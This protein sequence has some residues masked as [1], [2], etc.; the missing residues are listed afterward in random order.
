MTTLTREGGTPKTVREIGVELA[1]AFGECKPC[2]KGTC[3]HGEDCGFKEKQE[4][5]VR[6]A[7]C[8]LN[9]ETVKFTTTRS[10]SQDL[11]DPDEVELMLGE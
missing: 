10:R 1:E 8:A 7:L 2:L 6:E 11:V 3:C 9:R 4:A 5:K